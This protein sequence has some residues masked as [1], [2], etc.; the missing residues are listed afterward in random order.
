MLNI[1]YYYNR[2]PIS[3][4]LKLTS[5]S[6]W[7]LGNQILSTAIAIEYGF[8]HNFDCIM[9]PDK[10]QFYQKEKIILKDDLDLNKTPKNT[11]TESFGGFVEQS[12]KLGDNARDFIN[13][14]YDFPKPKLIDKDILHIHIR[15]GDI[16]EPGKGNGMVQPPCDYYCKEI[17]KRDWKK[18]IIVSED[19]LNPCIEYLTMKYPNVEY[20]GKNSLEIDIKEL[21]SARNIMMGRGTFI[22][23]LLLFMP[24]I[25][26]AHFPADGD[27]RIHNFI[28]NHNPK[29][30]IKH[31]EYSKYYKK[32]Q[33]IGGWSYSEKIKNLMLTM[34]Y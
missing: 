7:G 24:N 32:L 13:N 4:I 33:E 29:I 23:T 14:I 19:R 2:R 18:V 10:Q 15:S 11:Y 30:A 21:L 1:N 22:P 28:L 17:E 27:D 9:L 34:N 16:M 25:E 5:Y 12:L 8:K 20:F 3:K 31:E 6:G 26:S